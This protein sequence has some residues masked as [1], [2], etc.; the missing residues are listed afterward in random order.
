MKAPSNSNDPTR[1]K[2]QDDKLQIGTNALTPLPEYPVDITLM[3]KE[4]IQCQNIIDR[5]EK[6]A[7]FVRDENQNPVQSVASNNYSSSLFFIVLRN[8]CF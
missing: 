3:Y 7:G 5:I 2:L 6:I 4:I 1:I 8:Q